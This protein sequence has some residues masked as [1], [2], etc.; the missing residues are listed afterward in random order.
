MSL[1]KLTLLIINQV[2]PAQN[3]QIWIHHPVNISLLFP[4]VKH[5][6]S[7]SFLKTLDAV[8]SEVTEVKTNVS[9]NRI[10]TWPAALILNLYLINSQTRC[11][12]PF[13]C[14]FCSS[15]FPPPLM[16]AN[17]GINLFYKAF[18]DPLYVSM[19]KML[20]DTLYYMK[21]CWNPAI[22]SLKWTLL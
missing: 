14:L 1:G 20:R 19:F 3:L 13:V 7:D 11:S 6:V 8:V 16:K 15:W 22:I 18:S 2:S 4:Q 9:F 5:F 10:C 12:S 21:G 17:P